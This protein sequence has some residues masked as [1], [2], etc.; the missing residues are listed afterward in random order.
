MPNPVPLEY[1]KYYHIYNRGN[2]RENIF[3]EERNYLHFLRLYAEYIEPIAETYAYCLLYNHFHLLIRLKTGEEQ[4]LNLTGS[5][6][7]NLTGLEFVPKKPSQEF[8][9][10]FNA[11][12]KAIN[13]A[14]NRSGAL[15]QRPFGRLEVTSERYF[16][17][18]IT[19][20][21][22]NPEKHGLTEDFRTWPYSSY[23]ALLSRQ[24]TRLKRETVLA[25]FDG[26]TGVEQ[27][28]RQIIREHSLAPEDFD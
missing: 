3:R 11:Y 25:W 2:N 23:R 6:A 15:F 7:S 4:K 12:T 5:K 9:N 22:Q 8:S 20:I 26:P 21:H 10:L 13:K 19:Y 18:L 16:V 27:L 14:Y 17:Q 24:P 28:H 1:G